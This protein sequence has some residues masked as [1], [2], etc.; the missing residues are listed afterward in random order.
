[1]FYNEQKKHVRTKK[2]ILDDSGN[3]RKGCKII[4]KGEVY[5]RTLFTTKNKLFKQEQYL[6][7]VKCFYTDLINRMIDDDKDK[8]R[9]FDKNGLYLATKKIGKNNPKAEQI[10]EDNKARM[11]W[12][13]EVD[14]ALVS[15]VPEDEIRQIKKEYITD[16]IQESI[17]IWGNRP[18]MLR[19]IIITAITALASLISKVFRAAMELKDKLFHEALQKEYGR[20]IDF[21]KEISEVLNAGTVAEP[22]EITEKVEVAKESVIPDIADIPAVPKENAAKAPTPQIPPRLEMPPD[23]AVYLKYAKVKDELDR[24]NKQIFAAE[25]ERGNL[26]IQL[27]DL[28]GIARLTQKGSLERQIADKKDE[29]S[30]R[31]T[32]LSNTVRKYGFATVQDFYTA[33]R[34]TQSA[35][36]RHQQEVREWEETYGEKPQRKETLTE[37]LQ[38]YDR[39]KVHRQQTEQHYHQ[40]KD[41]GAR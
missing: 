23:A 12:N 37:R 9:V 11:Q 28:R 18:D 7:E 32:G 15:Q 3:V 34:T 14:R 5:E 24:Q 13:H 35:Y 10:K 2:E 31:K 40:Q 25:R 26:E 6:N 20:K 30:I 41:R 36:E 8:L 38:W 17:K 27:S 33:F 21:D 16:R 29:I 19:S 39:E 1:M 4:K 22:V